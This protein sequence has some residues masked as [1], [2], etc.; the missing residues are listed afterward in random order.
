MGEYELSE[1]FDRAGVVEKWG[2]GRLFEDLEDAG[3]GCS[4][5]FVFDLE[6]V[7]AAV[8]VAELDGRFIG[9]VLDVLDHSAKEAE[10]LEG[11]CFVRVSSEFESDIRD[12]RV[13]IE[14]DDLVF[15]F[16]KRT[17]D[18]AFRLVSNQ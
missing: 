16:G 4:A 6:G 15:G 10:D 7:E 14:L 5:A 2:R 12:G 17:P 18:L 3:V 9:D 11:E 8:E 13:G 1:I